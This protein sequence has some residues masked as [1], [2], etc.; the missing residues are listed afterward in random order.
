MKKYRAIF[1]ILLTTFCTCMLVTAFGADKPSRKESERV[2]RVFQEKVSKFVKDKGIKKEESERINSNIEKWINYNK[3]ARIDEFIDKIGD[4]DIEEI[5][6]AAQKTEIVSDVDVPIAA[7]PE[8]F[9]QKTLLTL[10][11][12]GI[13]HI[14]QGN[15]GLVSHFRGGSEEFAWDFVIV[16]HG[17]QA[18]GNANVNETHYCW[19]QP[20]LAPAP[21]VVV[22]IKD[23]L[24]DHLPYTPNPPRVGN[25]VYIDHENGEISLLY[26]LKQGSVM[27]KVG[28]KVKRGQPVGLCGDTGISMFPHL[29]FEHFKGN[30]EHHEKMETRFFGYYSWKV[31]P[32][33]EGERP[34][35]KLNLAGIPKRLDFVMN[36]NQLVDQTF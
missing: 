13:W 6:R 8:F 32:K 34:K 5:V 2:I 29:H 22:K 19:Q 7:A 9:G 4:S 16:K 17:Q 3:Y 31:E 24:P 20:I 30:L 14:V 26:H 25:H 10:P 23:D 33:K 35:M 11:V 36:S 1:A 12:N 27:V 28:D 15:Q 21:G 18:A